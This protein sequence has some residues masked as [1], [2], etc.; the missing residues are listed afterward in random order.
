MT[1]SGSSR[2]CRRAVHAEAEGACTSPSLAVQA[3]V[4]PDMWR[5]WRPAPTSPMLSVPPEAQHTDFQ[6]VVPEFEEK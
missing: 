1:G 3:L 2:A 4:I 6:E 5:M